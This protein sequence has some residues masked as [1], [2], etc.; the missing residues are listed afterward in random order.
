MKQ[1]YSVSKSSHRLQLLSVSEAP[2]SCV[3]VGRVELQSAEGNGLYSEPA[4]YTG[5]LQASV[6]TGVI[7]STSADAPGAAA[8]SGGRIKWQLH[9]IMRKHHVNV[10]SLALSQR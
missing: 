2:H 4:S 8:V 6:S 1:G 3:H 10:L 9:E 5:R 7:N